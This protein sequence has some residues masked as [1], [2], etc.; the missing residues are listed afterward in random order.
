MNC[1]SLRSRILCKLLCT[2]NAI[3]YFAI[4]ADMII[5]LLC[6]CHKKCTPVIYSTKKDADADFMKTKNI[7]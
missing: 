7:E 3:F 2:W 1:A 4:K 6:I 5:A